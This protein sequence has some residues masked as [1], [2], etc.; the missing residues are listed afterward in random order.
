MPLFQL[1]FQINDAVLVFFRNCVQFPGFEIF[2]FIQE[3]FITSYQF[4][5]L[6]FVVTQI[7]FYGFLFIFHLFGHAIRSL[8]FICHITQT[9]P[10]C[11]K[12][13]E[14]IANGSKELFQTIEVCIQN[15]TVLLIFVVYHRLQFFNVFIA[16]TVQSLV[17]KHSINDQS[18]KTCIMV[19]PQTTTKRVIRAY[20]L[21]TENNCNEYVVKFLV[22]NAFLDI[23]IST[24]S[25]KTLRIKR[26]LSYPN[27]PIIRTP[28]VKR[29]PLL[30]PGPC[31]MGLLIEN[32]TNIYSHSWQTKKKLQGKTNK[33]KESRV[34]CLHNLKFFLIRTKS[35]NY[36][37]KNIEIL[38]PAEKMGITQK[39]KS[40]QNESKPARSGN[41][42]DFIFF[43]CYFEIF[44][45]CMGERRRHQCK[46]TC[47]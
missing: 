34:T 8:Q 9:L 17:L 11:V 25:L 37:L 43:S 24:F 1:S 44:G 13:S 39:S 20:N 16:L 7:G 23:K 36:A 19:Y 12:R 21:G 27:E 29:F 41:I 3:N 15:A 45:I 42:N 6:C 47:V 40:S 32:N 14:R 10:H 5:H 26:R 33:G 31:Q 4:T 30:G 46:S 18:Y 22:K 28:N 38:P 35:Y 2:D